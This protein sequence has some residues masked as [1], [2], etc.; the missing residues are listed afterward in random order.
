L[1]ILLTGNSGFIGKNIGNYLLK[2]GHLIEGISRKTSSQEYPTHNLD[3]QNANALDKISPKK[4]FDCIIHCATL[5]K[6]NEINLM[7]KNNVLSTLNLLNFCKSKKI[8]KFI[9]ISG[10]N[11]YAQNSKIPKTEKSKILPSTNYGL[12]KLLQE[13][14]AEFY[15]INH[16]IDVIILRLSYTYGPNQPVEKMIPTLIN[17]YVK[18]QP[19]VL[20]KYKNGFQKIDLINIHDICNVVDKVLQLN[21]HFD[22]FNIS[23]GKSITVKDIIKILKQNITSNSNISIKE[24]DRKTDH[25]HYD[26]SHA[27]SI[28]NFKPIVTPELGIKELIKN[29]L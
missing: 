6:E 25:Y 24:I 3:L 22:I 12:T 19:I 20:N 27:K 11:V 9:L 17:K 15:S 10:H 21:R 2:K 28:L 1:K 23:F 29:Y 26:I 16:S 5:T 8:K 18:S 13:N 7:F 4:S 14:L